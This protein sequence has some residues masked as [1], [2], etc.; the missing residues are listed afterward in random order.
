MNN[1]HMVGIRQSLKNIRGAINRHFQDIGREI[2]IVRDKYFKP[3]NRA[4]DGNLKIRMRNGTSKPTTHKE[5]I[6]Q[7]DLEKIATY[8]SRAS[9]N[10]VILRHAVW[11]NIAIHFISRGMEFHHQLRLT[12]S[13]FM[14]RMSMANM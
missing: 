9:S 1:N 11:Y 5:I 13:S 4:L 3:A 14:I 6:E 10:P 8:L 2:D 12:R 7:N